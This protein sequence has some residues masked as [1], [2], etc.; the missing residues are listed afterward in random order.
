MKIFINLLALMA[1]AN[2][3]AIASNIVITFDDPNQ[4]G[5]PG[6]TLTF[7]GTITNTSSDTTLSDAIYFNSDSLN[8]TL[9]PASATIDD[10]FFSDVPIDLVGGASSGDIELFDI[11]LAD[12][13]SDPIGTYEGTYGLIGGMDQGEDSASED[14]AQAD[15][16]VELTP[17]PST[18]WLLL[19]GLVVSV[20]LPVSRKIQP[21]PTAG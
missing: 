18:F 2:A 21:P 6:E 17:E 20:G 15:F 10:L 16:S 5:V 3:T 8:F 4:I 19:G 12:P 11:I 13:V 9:S 1:L 14:L 7:F